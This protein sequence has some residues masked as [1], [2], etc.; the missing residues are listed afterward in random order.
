MK[1]MTKMEFNSLYSKD[2]KEVYRSFS[3]L[4]RVI[5][6]I[7]AKN[8]ES[9][10][11]NDESNDPSKILNQNKLFIDKYKQDPSM[12]MNKNGELAEYKD[13]FN[14]LEEDI[15]FEKY[16]KFLI[17]KESLQNEENSSLSSLKNLR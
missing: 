7:A 17:I 4:D 14:A 13:H 11:N 15:L 3:E 2:S 5:F 8:L 16:I 9:I 6:Y 10:L 12:I 1:G